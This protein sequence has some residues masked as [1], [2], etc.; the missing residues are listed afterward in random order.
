MFAIWHY[1]F[2]SVTSLFKLWYKSCFPQ[3]N[4]TY[5][6]IKWV[7]PSLPAGLSRAIL[8]QAE[9]RGDIRLQG[10]STPH[11]WHKEPRLLETSCL[12]GSK[13]K[14]LIQGLQ[15]WTW[16]WSHWVTRFNKEEAIKIPERPPSVFLPQSW[17]G[18]DL[19]EWCPQ[20][21]SIPCFKPDGNWQN[22]PK[23]PS[24]TT[25]LSKS[26]LWTR[27]GSAV[28][29]C[30]LLFQRTTSVVPSIDI[31]RLPTTHNSSSRG[32]NALSW[33]LWNTHTQVA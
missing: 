19:S 3:G 21:K 29:E 22:F 10:S 23:L 13:L 24:L 31:T 32:P 2:I 15:P 25:E 9:R 18:R 17:G 8:L 27:D 16:R 5:T 1:S 7:E 4:P 33:P 26:Q 30:L 20:G 6:L 28:Q 12:T 11:P 14:H